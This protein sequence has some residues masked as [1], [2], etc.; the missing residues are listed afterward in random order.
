MSVPT[1]YLIAALAIGVLV[2][3]WS[4]IRRDRNHRSKLNLDDLLLGDDGKI[5]KAAI[6]L[7][8]AFA[9]T[10]WL[11][12]VLT[13]HDKMTEGYFT[14]Y[15]AFWIAPTVTR[16][17]VNRPLPLTQETTISQTTVTPTA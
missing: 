8:G 3:I 9:F 5:S 4:L 6:V 17:I 11:M 15:G 7:L 1:K 12:V 16:L 13:V 14:A 2:I 10:T